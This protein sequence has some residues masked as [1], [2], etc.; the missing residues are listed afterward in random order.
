MWVA[1]H[2]LGIAVMWTATDRSRQPGGR[3]YAVINFKFYLNPLSVSGIAVFYYFDVMYSILDADI[4]LD[5]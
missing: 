2:Y 4:F 5:L 3:F 1:K